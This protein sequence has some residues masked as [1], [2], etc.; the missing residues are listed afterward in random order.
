MKETVHVFSIKRVQLLQDNIQPVNHNIKT[1]SFPAVLCF[2]LLVM[3]G[4]CE[5]M[6]RLASLNNTDR[7]TTLQYFLVAWLQVLIRQNALADQDTTLCGT[8]IS[9]LKIC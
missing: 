8:G 1:K 9:H 3:L 6:E 2:S 7:L 5:D 4:C